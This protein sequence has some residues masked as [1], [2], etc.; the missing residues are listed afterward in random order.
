MRIPLSKSEHAKIDFTLNC[1]D[2]FGALAAPIGRAMNRFLAGLTT[3][4]ESMSL[5]LDGREGHLTLDLG[6]CFGWD[7]KSESSPSIK[8]SLVDL[9]RDH[10][11]LPLWMYHASANR[12]TKDRFTAKEAMTYAGPFREQLRECIRLI[13]AVEAQ[14]ESDAAL[15][16]IK[17]DRNPMAIHIDW[18]GLV[19]SP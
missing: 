5:D 12:E 4:D 3:N 7:E 17:P 2:L 6:T 8:I 9:V 1:K 13:D 18:N 11:E 10:F 16:F 19:G 15:K 14:I